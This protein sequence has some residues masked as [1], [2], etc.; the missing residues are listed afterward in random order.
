MEYLFRGKDIQTGEWIEGDRIET[1]EAVLIAPKDLW[2]SSLENNHIE[3]EV[4]QVH[5]DTVGMWTQR[6]DRNGNKIFDGDIYKHG[7][8][9]RFV[10]YRLNWCITTLEKTATMLL[11]FC[12]K[13]ELEG[14]CYGELT[15]QNIHDNPELLESSKQEP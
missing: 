15:G 4:R 5:P 14:R 8:S 1:D 10:E 7:E 11:S 9:V 3:I 12:A 2:A 13:Y 6:L